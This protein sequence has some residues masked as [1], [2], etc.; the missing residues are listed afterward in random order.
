LSL[1]PPSEMILL[2]G[3]MQ[4]PSLAEPELYLDE[5]LQNSKHTT[6]NVRLHRLDD[7]D[8]DKDLADEKT[9]SV[10][11]DGSFSDIGDSFC[12]MH[13]IIRHTVSP[14]PIR[15]DKRAWK[16]LPAPLAAAEGRMEDAPQVT[17]HSEP[18]V[19]D[20]SVVFSATTR[21]VSF[22]KIFIRNYAQT[23]GDNPSV[24]MGTPI[25][26]DWEFEEEQ[27]LLVD[28]YEAGITRRRTARQMMLNY[29]NRR[30]LLIHKWG[31]TESE[32]D[33][34]EKQVNA[35]RRQRSMTLALL[36]V[37]FMEDMVESACRKAR[38]GMP[39]RKVLPE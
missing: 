24:S 38:R 30:N 15:T 6:T 21:R 32:V 3:A 35:I 28:D 29:Y 2:L 8:D 36:K 23:V 7:E 22:D 9:P 34:G 17:A 14:I 39:K 5:E 27:P 26:L 37:S 19:A 13:S 31:H 10:T 4:L 1:E 11:E 16:V 18:D 25:Q 33:E 12:S 20:T